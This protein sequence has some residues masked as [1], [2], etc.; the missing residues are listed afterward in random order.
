MQHTAFRAP[1]GGPQPHCPRIRPACRVFQGVC[2]LVCSPGFTQCSA[3]VAD[4]LSDVFE[5]MLDVC[6]SMTMS[7]FLVV[8]LHIVTGNQCIVR[9]RFVLSATLLSF[10]QLVRAALSRRSSLS[11]QHCCRHRAARSCST[12]SSTKRRLCVTFW[13]AFH[14]PTF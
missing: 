7:Q 2:A 1:G 9:G 6:R 11:S 12:N 10:A 13:Y 3:T 5:S 8:V 14:F 4:D